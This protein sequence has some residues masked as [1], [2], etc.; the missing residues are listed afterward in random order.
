MIKR[1]KG[2]SH[3]RISLISSEF[4]DS[5]F[6]SALS[7]RLFG[8]DITVVGRELAAK[9]AAYTKPVPESQEPDEDTMSDNENDKNVEENNEKVD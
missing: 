1:Q 4:Y 2:T 9:Q 7:M 8:E 6:H 3:K 5:P